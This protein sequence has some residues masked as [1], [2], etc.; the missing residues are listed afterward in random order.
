MA[1]KGGPGRPKGSRNKLGEEFLDDLIE[2]WRASGKK[3]L[4]LCAARE[5]TQFCKLVSNILPKEVLSMA[6]NVNATTTFSDRQEA[7]A[8]L[9]AFRVCQTEPIEDVVEGQLV[10]EGWNHDDD[11]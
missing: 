7:K 8:F 1:N 11:D 10:P 5:P 9:A 3:A 6:L 4:A 2:E